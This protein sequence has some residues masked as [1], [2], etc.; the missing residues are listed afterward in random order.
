VSVPPKHTFLKIEPVDSC[1][2]ICSCPPD[3]PGLP[4][5]LK[6]EAHTDPRPFELE[7]S[8]SLTC[9]PWCCTR[10][11]RGCERARASCVTPLPPLL[12]PPRVLKCSLSTS[13]HIPVITFRRN[14][15]VPP[16]QRHFNRHSLRSQ[17]SSQMPP[18]C[19]HQWICTWPSMPFPDRCVLRWLLRAAGIP[20][21]SHHCSGTSAA[22]CAPLG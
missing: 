14:V 17:P 6:N 3:S 7:D 13:K 20:R 21:T 1:F 4:L 12:P 22:I 16:L 10:A 5:Q 2:Q 15:S 19:L 11:A 8:S 18:S 9:R